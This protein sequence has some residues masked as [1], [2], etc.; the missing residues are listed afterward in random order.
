M[1]I[2]W[3]IDVYIRDSKNRL[4]GDG[5]GVDVLDHNER[6]TTRVIR[7]VYSMDLAEWGQADSLGCG[8]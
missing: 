7:D 8:N 2:L 3:L 6:C 4:Q 1:S 5:Y